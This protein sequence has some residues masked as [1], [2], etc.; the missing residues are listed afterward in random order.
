APKGIRSPREHDASVRG[1]VSSDPR[2]V[3]PES[4]HRRLAGY[5]RAGLPPDDERHLDGAKHPVA[6]DG[7][8]PAEGRGG[9]S[10]VSTLSPGR[11]EQQ[12]AIRL[13]NRLH[14]A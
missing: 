12:R 11:R 8:S 10:L 4:S 9:I 14:A 6:H 1:Q 3:V 2:A 13:L 7:W 5:V